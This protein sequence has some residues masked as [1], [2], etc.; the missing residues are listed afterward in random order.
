MDSRIASTFASCSLRSSP[1]LQ[2]GCK[3][4]HS[5][6][7]FHYPPGRL[8]STIRL[9]VAALQL[10]VF[11]PHFHGF[12][13]R[14]VIRSPPAR[15]PLHF[16]PRK[17]AR[18]A[19][20]LLL[21]VRWTAPGLVFP[22]PVRRFPRQIHHRACQRPHKP[23]VQARPA[24][25]STKVCHAPR[26]SPFHSLA[27]YAPDLADVLL[28]ALAKK[29]PPA[30]LRRRALSGCLPRGST[31]SSSRPV[32][33]SPGMPALMRSVAASTPPDRMP[34]RNAV[35][36]SAPPAPRLGSGVPGGRGKLP[37]HAHR[38]TRH[39]VYADGWQHWPPR[40]PPRV[41]SQLPQ[42]GRSVALVDVPSILRRAGAAQPVCRARKLRR[43]GEVCGLRVLRV[44]R[45]FPPNML[46]RAF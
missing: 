4:A 23:R 39:R 41:A 44:G 32:L 1:T 14:I 42:A 11:I 15:S 45:I 43:H 5:R 16:V 40:P 19:V 35:S 28:R 3:A 25:F 34:Y 2:P 18:N 10:P 46:A 12:P 36:S 7:W 29:R 27:R 20:L 21:R 9:C 22:L 37:G 8:L 30:F 31:T 33:F 38:P 24:A 26:S 17:Q 6:W 13:Y